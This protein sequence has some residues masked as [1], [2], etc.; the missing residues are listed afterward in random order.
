MSPNSHS[1]VR[2][3]T[4]AER[5]RNVLSRALSAQVS[6]LDEAEPSAP[7]ETTSVVLDRPDS[8]RPPLR[9]VV[10]EVAD[11]APLPVADRVR[12][13]V[14]LYGHA[15]PLP[16][17]PGAIRLRAVR[18][19]LEEPELRTPIAPDELRAAEPDPVASREGAFLCHLAHDHRELVG[20]L[21]R[22]IDREV[23]DGARRAVPL[24]LDRHGLVFRVEYRRGHR[25]VLLAFPTPAASFD[26]LRAGL[27]ELALRAHCPCPGG[28]SATVPR[29]R[30]S[31]RDLLDAGPA[32][33]RLCATETPDPDQR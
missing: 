25:D 9:P 19:E 16:D 27:R 7:T 15:D 12:A 11:V 17:R 32:A 31:L 28:S 29:P 1:P 3:A 26:E 24:A 6:W 10:V 5:A 18:V 23:L 8:G 4:A 22:L 20:V 13:R 30:R 2:G 33:A 14:R 21:T